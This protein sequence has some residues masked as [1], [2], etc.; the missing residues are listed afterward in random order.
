MSRP[1]LAVVC[2]LPAAGHLIPL[3]KIAARA[4]DFAEVQVVVPDEMVRVA[5]FYGFDVTGYGKVEPPDGAAALHAYGM[6]SEVS[7][8]FGGLHRCLRGYFYPLMSRIRKSMPKLKRVVSE[9]QPTWILADYPGYFMEELTELS[10]HAGAPLYTHNVSPHSEA[11]ETWT[12]KGCLFHDARSL[13]RG[14]FEKSKNEIGLLARQRPGRPD[15]TD[16]LPACIAATRIPARDQGGV[17]HLSTGTRFLER[18]LLSDRLLYAG[19]DRVTLPAL[20]PLGGSLAPDVL[21][22]LE[23][24]DGPVAYVSFGTLIRDNLILSDVVGALLGRGMRVLVQ[25]QTNGDASVDTARVRHE[26]WVPQATMVAHPAVSLVVTHGGSSSVEE[27]LWHGKPMIVIPHAWD[28]YYN[29]W[30]ASMLGASV[31]VRRHGI[32]LRRRLQTATGHATGGGPGE[33]ARHLSALMHACW[34]ERDDMIADIFC[35]PA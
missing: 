18:A 30:I 32:A 33:A 4:R 8:V 5:A 20:P 11:H 24:G 1:R 19:D 3:L 17:V 10:S 28:Q 31:T 25:G 14:I 6:G 27:A 13:L 2:L 9:L 21:S 23:T 35:P 7:R 29:A 12:L 34:R 22:W 16:A 26:A 15:L